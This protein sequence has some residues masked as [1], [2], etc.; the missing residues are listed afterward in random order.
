MASEVSW[1]STH[2]S[3]G[4]QEVAVHLELFRHLHRLGPNELQQRHRHARVPGGDWGRRL[5]KALP[6]SLQVGR[7][8]AVWSHVGKVIIQLGI[9]RG[10]YLSHFSLSHEPSSREV[11]CVRVR[12][13]LTGPAREG[14]KPNRFIWFL[15][16]F[17]NH[18]LSLKPVSQ[19]NKAIAL[20]TV[21]YHGKL[22]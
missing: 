13:A 21:R 17:S 19:E 18:I 22:I 16:I 4:L 20:T 10:L 3:I 6:V 15:F 7:G 5:H 8:W 12:D 1:C 11:L 14:I 2:L 9:A